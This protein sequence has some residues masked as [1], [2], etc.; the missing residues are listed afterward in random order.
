MRDRSSYPAAHAHLKY[1]RHPDLSVASQ[2][3]VRRIVKLPDLAKNP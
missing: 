1:R 2:I 3:V